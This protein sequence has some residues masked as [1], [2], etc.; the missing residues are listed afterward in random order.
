MS[1]TAVGNGKCKRRVLGVISYN[2]RCYKLEH[3]HQ[4]PTLCHVTLQIIGLHPYGVNNMT[5][6]QEVALKVPS[7]GKKADP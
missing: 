4:S 1:V 5:E 7:H 2:I 3:Y 6:L